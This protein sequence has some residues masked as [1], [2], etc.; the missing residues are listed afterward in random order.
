MSLTVKDNSFD[1]G[2]TSKL[3]TTYFPYYVLAGKIGEKCESNKYLMKFLEYVEMVNLSRPF[4]KKLRNT[5][6]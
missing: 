6:E 4:P 5:L 2:N 1:E 3:T